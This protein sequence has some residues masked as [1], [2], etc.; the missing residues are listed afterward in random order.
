M[1]ENATV[2]AGVYV[3]LVLGSVFIE[4]YGLSRVDPRGPGPMPRPYFP[5]RCSTPEVH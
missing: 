2:R 4:R 1:R 3:V 5:T